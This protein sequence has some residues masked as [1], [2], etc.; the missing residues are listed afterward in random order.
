MSA[1]DYERF[2]FWNREMKDYLAKL[3]K[4]KLEAKEAL[5]K[6]LREKEQEKEKEA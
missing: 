2:E 1:N 6:E 4:E 5:E 3:E